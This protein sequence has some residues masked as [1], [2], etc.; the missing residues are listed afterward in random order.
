M[1]HERVAILA[2]AEKLTEVPKASSR[3]RMT[4]LEAVEAIVPQVKA[5]RAAGHDWER[6]REELEKGGFTISTATLVTYFKKVAS[7]GRRRRRGETARR[8]EGA[9]QRPRGEAISH[10]SSESGAAAADDPS[11]EGDRGQSDNGSGMPEVKPAGEGQGDR[12]RVPASDGAGEGV[13]DGCP[14]EGRAGRG[15]G[16]EE[17]RREL[18]L[19]RAR[20]PRSVS[21][22]DL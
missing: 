17:S 1:L 4:T 18:E 6:V 14:E 13:G 16:G 10:P 9:G 15:E 11:G 5:W 22:E 2:L 21:L 3:E 19:Q 12:A 7:G 8:A 20:F